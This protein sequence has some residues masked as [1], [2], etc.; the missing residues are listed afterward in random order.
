M[1]QAQVY[2]VKRL[3][4]GQI[5]TRTHSTCENNAFT[6]LKSNWTAMP[7]VFVYMYCKTRTFHQ[8]IVTIFSDEQICKT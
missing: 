3:D 2:Y 7:L 5:H 1:R 8:V 4:S 6:N